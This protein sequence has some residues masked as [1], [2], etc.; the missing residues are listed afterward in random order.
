MSSFLYRID[1][2]ITDIRFPSSSSVN[3]SDRGSSTT[4]LTVDTAYSS[5]KQSAS[6]LSISSTLGDGELNTDFNLTTSQVNTA[7]HIENYL[8]SVEENKRQMDLEIMDEDFS[9]TCSKPQSPASSY[10]NDIAPFDTDNILISVIHEL[11]EQHFNCDVIALDYAPHFNESVMQ[12]W[13]LFKIQKES[14]KRKRITLPEV[15]QPKKRRSEANGSIAS[16]RSFSIEYDTAPPIRD[17]EEWKRQQTIKKKETEEEKSKQ[18]VENVATYSMNQYAKNVL[19]KTV[20]DEFVCRICFEPGNI[21]LCSGICG[22]RYHPKCAKSMERLTDS[23][24]Q[25]YFKQ[26]FVKKLKCND[27]SPVPVGNKCSV[28]SILCRECASPEIPK[29]FVCSKGDGVR[30]RCSEKNCGKAYH[31]ECLNYWPQH[32]KSYVGKGG[33]VCPCHTCQICISENP[34]SLKYNICGDRKFI[35][36]L[37]C[38]ATYHRKSSCIPAGSAL[39][40]HSEMICPRHRANKRRPIN[41]NWCFLCTKGGSLICCETCPSAFHQ[42]CLKLQ[43]PDK[44]ICEECES[45]RLPLYGEIVWAK[46]GIHKWWPSI[47]LPPSEVSDKLLACQQDANH[48]CVFFFGTHN[49]AWICRDYVYLYQEDDC[50]FNNQEFQGEFMFRKACAEAKECYA[51]MKMKPSRYNSVGRNSHLKP[52]P[53]KKIKYNY[54]VPPVKW[55]SGHYS[56]TDCEC[57]PNDPYACSLNSG[58]I[59]YYLCI[60]CN[61][62][63]RAGENCQNQRFE[64]CIYPKLEVRRMESRGWGLIAL[65]NIPNNTFIIEYVGDVINDEEFRRRFEQSR[66]EKDENFYFLQLGHNLYID[67]G[68]RGNLA[69]FANHS[70]AP[71]CAAQTWTVKGKTRIGLFSVMDIPAVS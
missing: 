12:L 23:D 57:K 16:K 24:W 27:P 2:R 10:T 3:E 47:I 63:C 67:A 22:G 19:F 64:K 13:S 8:L 25:I 11:I 44:Y 31:L 4:P 38:P 9:T 43:V 58:C 18:V 55:E 65:E 14:K 45:G 29:C 33:L 37:L 50:K 52:A 30:I 26:H 62:T 51:L 69:R 66:K 56:F 17:P 15:S 53:Y 35:K 40:S 71:N 61:P 32:K 42:E 6:P 41:A 59:N 28:K 21:A 54:V 46:L 34:N 49:C 70:C 68:R 20:P 60:E 5:M 1:N 36:C 7:N 39:L 48:F